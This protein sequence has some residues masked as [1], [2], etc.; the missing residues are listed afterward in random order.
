M[1]GLLMIWLGT[2]IKKD[3]LQDLRVRMQELE[4]LM[5]NT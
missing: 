1:F 2:K 4:I 3:G 5:M